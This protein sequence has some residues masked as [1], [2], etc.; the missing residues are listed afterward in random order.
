MAV[1]S[2]SG[3]KTSNANKADDGEATKR[4]SA[5]RDGDRKQSNDREVRAQDDAKG[6]KVD[7][8]A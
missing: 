6:K 8:D 3:S 1:E 7:V 2:V 4:R 5:V